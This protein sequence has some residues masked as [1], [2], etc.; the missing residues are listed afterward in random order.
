MIIIDPI[1]CI[2]AAIRFFF[3]LTALIFQHIK[4][5]LEFFTQRFCIEIN[6]ILGKL[7]GQVLLPGTV[8]H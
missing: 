6:P 4:E 8:I 5:A 7:R 3:S 1:E 2:L